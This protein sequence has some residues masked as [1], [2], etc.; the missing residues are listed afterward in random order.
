MKPH[1][2]EALLSLRLADRDIKAFEVLI[3]DPEVHLTIACFHAQQAV[4]KSLKAVLFAHEIEFGRT[5]DLIQ[6]TVLLRGRGISVPISDAGLRQLN[7]FAV[8]FRYD[9]M[10]NETIPKEDVANMVTIIRNW[11]EKVIESARTNEEQEAGA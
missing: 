1:I 10:E 6:L 9:E 7:P 2:E 8:T 4:E 5:H 11:A 3:K